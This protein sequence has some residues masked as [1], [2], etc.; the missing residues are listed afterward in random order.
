[1]VCRCRGWG[2][3]GR[4]IRSL[5][6]ATGVLALPIALTYF[7]D[8]A[9]LPLAAPW[10]LT[11]PATALLLARAFRRGEVGATPPLMASRDEVARRHAP[12]PAERRV[13]T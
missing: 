8:P 5:L 7:V 12:P 4:W 3:S 1:M 6:L 10:S 13:I 11:V 2:R 9:F